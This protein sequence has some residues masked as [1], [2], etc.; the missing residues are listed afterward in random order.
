MTGAGGRGQRWYRRADRGSGAIWVL[1]MGAVVL[2]IGG[3]TAARGLAVVG[4]HDAEA[5]ADF[6]A[7]AAAADGDLGARA[8]CRTAAHIAADNR[9]RLVSCRVVARVA[10]VEVAQ[11]LP[12]RLLSRWQAHGWARAGPAP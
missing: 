12:S 3:A 4:R 2:L 6:A 1:A 9:A 8:A 11:P 7:L 5:A 10:D